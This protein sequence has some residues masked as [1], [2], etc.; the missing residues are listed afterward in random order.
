M[1]LKV[2]GRY[3]LSRKLGGGAFGEVFLGILFYFGLYN[4]F[5][6]RYRFIN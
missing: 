2:A 1:E 4:K 3:R 6:F 5:K